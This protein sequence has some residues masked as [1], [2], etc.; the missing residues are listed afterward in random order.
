MSVFVNYKLQKPSKG[1]IW[2]Q[3]FLFT[4]LYSFGL[5]KVVSG[6]KFCCLLS[7]TV[8]DCSFL[9]NT[10][11]GRYRFKCTVLDYNDLDI[12]ISP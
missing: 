11:L 5:L 2:Y 9:D 12:Q 3:V 4:F 1:G 8:L 10:D 6:I 7:C